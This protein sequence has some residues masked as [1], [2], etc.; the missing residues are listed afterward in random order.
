MTILQY[1]SDRPAFMGN[2][3]MKSEELLRIHHAVPALQ[4][5]GFGTKA[6]EYKLWAF[7]GQGFGGKM[8]VDFE[9]NKEDFVTLARFN[10]KADTVCI[11]VGKVIHS[12]Y[13]ELYCSPYYYIQMDNARKYMH[14]LANFGH[15]QVLVFGDYSEKMKEL[16]AIMGFNVVDG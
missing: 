12:E 3:N 2:P 9:E 8:Q 7:T 16:S 11:K 15:H 5:N 6:L 14:N 1:T 4:M 10:P 13:E